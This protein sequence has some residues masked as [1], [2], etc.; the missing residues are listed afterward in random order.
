[1]ALF[2]KCLTEHRRCVPEIIGYCKLACGSLRPLR[3][4]LT[5]S[6]ASPGLVHVKGDMAFESGSRRNEREA[7]ALAAWIA[8]N[9]AAFIAHYG[10]PLDDA[11]LALSPLLRPKNAPCCRALIQRDWS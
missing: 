5:L 9:Q 6:L 8:D 2:M 11:S 7:Q 3:P 1:M 4:S 10:R